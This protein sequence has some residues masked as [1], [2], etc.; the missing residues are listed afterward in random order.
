[1]AWD[2]V[3]REEC[4]IVFAM[5]YR[6]H[7]IPSD[8]SVTSKTLLPCRGHE[9]SHG[10][11]HLGHMLY[12]WRTGHGH[13]TDTSRVEP[14]A[15]AK[16][17]DRHPHA[18]GLTPPPSR[19]HP[20]ASTLAPPPSRLH[21]RGSTLTPPPSR[22]GASCDWRARLTAR[23]GSRA[24]RTQHESAG[25]PHLEPRRTVTCCARTGRR[26]ASVD[27]WRPPRRRLA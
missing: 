18:C 22:G 24:D 25:A 7:D 17:I 20:H 2:L 14:T 21:P 1:M 9:S 27:L 13:R 5:R 4:T 10:A 12:I 8:A 11:A 6:A 3:T 15:H 26:R 23:D 19:L 16:R